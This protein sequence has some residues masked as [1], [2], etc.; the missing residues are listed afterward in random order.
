MGE[1]R[2]LG[3]RRGSTRTL[4]QAEADRIRMLG[5][6]RRNASSLWPALRRE[7]VTR[8]GLAEAEAIAKQVVEASGGAAIGS[9]RQIADRFAEALEKSGVD[10]SRFSSIGAAWAAKPASAAA[11]P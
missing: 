10:I 1:P 3:S 11:M 4:A 9:S 6:G 2:P 7:R 5:E 8:V